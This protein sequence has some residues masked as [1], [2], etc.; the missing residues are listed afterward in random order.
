MK[1]ILLLL[2]LL[3]QTILPI[4]ISAQSKEPAYVCIYRSNKFLCNAYEFDLQFRGVDIYS[5]RKNTAIEYQ[6]QNE[7]KLKIEVKNWSPSWSTTLWLNIESG[8]R[9]YVKIDCSISGLS[10][11]YNQPTSE[12]EW[13]EAASRGVVSMTEDPNVP[14]IE[15][16]QPVQIVQK[17]KT[18]TVKQI[19]YVNQ[20]Q[21]DRPSQKH[22]YK[23][24]SDVD[25]NIPSNPVTNEMT[26]A[27]IVGNE[28]YSS[29]QTEVKSEMNVEFARND[30]NTF[31]EYL[32]K[33]FGVPEKNIT[34]LQDATYG[35]IKQALSKLSLLAK[36]TGGKAQLVF[37]YAGH[38]MPD[39]ITKDAYL[40]PVDIS[41]SHVTSGI[42]LKDVYTKLTE[43]SPERVYVFMDACFTGGGRNQGLLAARGV[44]I[45]PKEESL[46]GNIVV[47]NS[48]SGIQSS[49]PF[50]EKNHGMFT[51]Y[52]LKKFQDT[53]GSV[54]L[55]V[56]S[57]Y[58][59]EK[60]SLDALLI[61]SKEQN[62]QIQT[63]ID[64]AEEWSSWKLIK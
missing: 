16:N 2:L 6:F 47:F 25:V 59:K 38:G 4:T 52:L 33:T 13:K 58:I 3:N 8:K 40:M 26:F 30:A 29:Y 48:S 42:K 35:Q 24:V 34:L 57:E 49:L 28:D 21:S 51:Y 55:G 63:S 10:L 5:M 22:V 41:G 50:K 23:P 27:L 12:A 36:T 54:E 32:I 60:V 14:V 11:S 9:Y 44:S 46:R 43:N 1:K 56:L 61:N 18:D 19:V 53:K 15:L 37:Y 62:P 45:K 31:K 64:V 39:E 7:G 20:A 17:P